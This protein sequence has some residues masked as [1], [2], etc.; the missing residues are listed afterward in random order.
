[1]EPL[2][3]IVEDPETPAGRAFALTIQALIVYSLIT[4]SIETVPD[5]SAGTRRFLAISEAVVVVIFTVEYLLRVA[6]TRPRLGYICSFFGLV[7]LLAILP[8]YLSTGI[9][10]R[11]LRVLRFLRLVRILKL[12]RYGDAA[13]RFKQAYCIVREELFLFIGMT[14]ILLYLS[15]VGIYYFERAAQPE[16]FGSV[17]HCLWWAVSSLTTV[18]YG[19]V[20]PITTG[21]RIFTSFVLLLGL[22]VIAVPAGLFA[23]ALSRVR[24]LERQEGP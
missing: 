8:F 2:R 19:D 22:G 6:V 4:F 5:L 11:S 1:M 9:D 7:D 17:F 15:A 24:G 13:R 12:A 20:F 3:H 21:G 10:L 23:S 14:A 18:G 16:A